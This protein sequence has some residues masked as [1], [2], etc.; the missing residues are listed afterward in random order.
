MPMT[1]TII[2]DSCGLSSINACSPLIRDF[3]LSKNL[4]LDTVIEN[5]ALYTS[6]KS[7]DIIGKPINIG[8]TPFLSS[9]PNPDTGIEHQWTNNRREWL[10]A[11]NFIADTISNDSYALACLNINPI[12]SFP[13]L[14]I[15]PFINQNSQADVG[16]DVESPT[17]LHNNL[18]KNIT[19][20]TVNN[21]SELL[22]ALNGGGSAGGEAIEQQ[23][24]IGN[25]PTLSTI[26]ENEWSIESETTSDNRDSILAYNTYKSAQSQGITDAVG[27]TDEVNLISDTQI[28]DASG[29]IYNIPSG[30]NP[31]SY[32]RTGIDVN[33]TKLANAGEVL[34]QSLMGKNKYVFNNEEIADVG[35]RIPSNVSNQTNEYLDD[36]HQLNVG[37]PDTEPINIIGSL[38]TGGLGF[39][40]KGLVPYFDL[41]TSLA[42]RTLSAANIIND[43]PIG[44][45]GAQQMAIALGNNA[46]FNLQQETIG[47]INLNPLNLL[48]GGDIIIPN[49]DITVSSTGLG[50]VLDFGAKL[51]GFQAPMSE[52]AED[53]FIYNT[54]GQ[55][56]I[57]N[58]TLISN[59]G[60]GQVVTLFANLNMNQYKPAY[61]DPRTANSGINPNLYIKDINDALSPSVNDFQSPF[62]DSPNA[63][64]YKD[65]P[66]ADVYDN[67][68]TFD[69]MYWPDYGTDSN[70]IKQQPSNPYKNKNS[71]LYKTFELFKNDTIGTLIN[72]NSR[73][74]EKSEIQTGGKKTD[75][76]FKISKG[77]AITKGDGDF[78]RTWTSINRYNKVQDLVKHKGILQSQSTIH[79]YHSQSSVL[80]DNGFPRISP[81]YGDSEHQNMRRFMFSIENLAWADNW[82]D[83]PPSEQGVGDSISGM[84]GRIMWFPPYDISF[85]DNTSVNWETTQ[86]IGR[87]EPIYTYGYTERTGTLQF[88]IISDHP[89][90][91]NDVRWTEEKGLIEGIV[92]GC[93]DI[94]PSI[95]MKLT[96]NELE[97][98]SVSQATSKEHKT[99]SNALNEK[100]SIYFPESV[101]TLDVINARDY[102]GVTWG[103]GGTI[104]GNFAEDSSVYTYGTA[105]ANANLNKDYFDYQVNGAEKFSGWAKQYK[106]TIVVEIEG[107]TSSEGSV[108]YNTRLSLARAESVKDWITT[109]FPPN[110]DGINRR[111]TIVLTKIEDNSGTYDSIT[112]TKHRHAVVR[113]Y[114]D[115]NF[116]KTL[117]PDVIDDYVTP[118]TEL[119]LGPK[120]INESEYFFKLQETNRFVFDDIRQ[121]LRWFHPAF[122][123]IT[124]EGLNS[125]L[126]FLQQC[127][128][129]GSTSNKSGNPDNLAFGRPP[130]CILR[131]G[132]F[133]HTK[134]IID[135]INFSYEPLL[136]DLNPEGIGVQPMLVT[137]DLNFKFI[138]GSALEGPI[139]RLQ[140]AVSFNFFANNEQYSQRPDYIKNGKLIEGYKS[141][142][143][144]KQWD[145]NLESTRFNPIINTN[146]STNDINQEIKNNI[147]N[148]QQNQ[149]ASTIS[150]K[151][152]FEFSYDSDQRIIQVTFIG[153][154]GVNIPQGNY[155]WNIYNTDDAVANTISWSADYDLTTDINSFQV[156]KILASDE[157]VGSNL[158]RAKIK[159]GKDGTNGDYV[160]TSL[161]QR[162]NIVAT[163]ATL[164]G[165]GSMTIPT[166]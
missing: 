1:P 29:D 35:N 2:P 107:Y 19:T 95:K 87:A 112:A 13:D 91:M 162:I 7:N 32:P 121:K 68:E 14:N 61:S 15:I 113:I 133:Y 9:T 141:N 60:K 96:P 152:N 69:Y 12:G 120:F 59:T 70:L 44:R 38:L 42:G 159:Y 93:R 102:Q 5:S 153:D 53:S 123:S 81:Y 11:K 50:K 21:N 150:T 27:L 85:T 114:T 36:K 100:F 138:G 90:Y 132:D 46:A 124:P 127:G 31:S 25:K 142:E 37:G 86:F 82:A 41:R 125:R 23:V 105:T 39:S 84:K 6:L 3:L 147:N 74:S 51:M 118:T 73:Q 130:V 128:R 151:V 89:S 115:P 76:G 16:I 129:Q 88:K 137:V 48:T 45:I 148:L 149:A 165:C 164:N 56:T 62:F 22:S 52:M 158:N 157:T 72:S 49:Y 26:G 30:T 140:N 47:H 161:T 17:Y 117:T 154:N 104:Q 97:A 54:M 71:I 99:D 143:T 92:A 20:D 43:T 156:T 135:S 77:S 101:D 126:T 65:D 109:L 145:I 10:L 146:N 34:R 136:W 103:T 110:T 4:K 166:V 57:R 131:I 94:P 24:T 67:K 108:N 111:I 98:I 116:D 63:I 58:T 55:T 40:D 134:I 28:T 160:S 64:E 75:N 119:P 106:D 33:T 139:N 144:P 122:H 8:E 78:C 83:L 80:D 66:R 163:D 155:Y 79:R 18:V